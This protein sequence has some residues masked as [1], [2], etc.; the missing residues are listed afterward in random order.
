MTYLLKDT[1]IRHIA[2]YLHILDV[3]AYSLSIVIYSGN[4]YA[5]NKTQIWKLWKSNIG[6]EI[7]YN[8][9]SL[10]KLQEVSLLSQIYNQWFY[11]PYY[12]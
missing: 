3:I 7:S 12:K 8:K 6:K 1:P 9:D 10:R 5:I 4:F 11:Y 2:H